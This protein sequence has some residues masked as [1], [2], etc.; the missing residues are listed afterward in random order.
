MAEIV[1]VS[2]D[3][4]RHVFP[5]GT[6]REVINRA[7]KKYASTKFVPMRGAAT[8]V[9][10]SSASD[11]PIGERF[12]QGLMDIAE[13][14]AQLAAHLFPGSMPTMPAPM[15]PTSYVDQKVAEGQQAYADKRSTAGGQGFDFP[16]TVGNMSAMAPVA[17]VAAPEAAM[18][19]MAA[20]GLGA[21]T[22]AGTSALMPVTDTEKSFAGQKLGQM[23]E[24][25]IAGLL[26]GGLTKGLS[27]VVKPKVS[28]EIELLKSKGVTPTLGQNLGPM[29]A[30]MEDR[31]TGI[32]VLGNAIAGAQ[33]RSLDQFNKAVLDD[34]LQPI[35][36]SA[37]GKIG[38]DGADEVH[39]ILDQGYKELLPKLTYKVDDQFID[40]LDKLG[41]M[42]SELPEAQRTRFTEIVEKKLIDRLSKTEM[43]DGQTWKGVESELSRIAMELRKDASFDQRELGSAVRE[44]LVAFRGNLQRTNPEFAPQLGKLND[45]YSR[46][47]QLENATSRLGTDDGV[48]T[49]SQFL[50]AVRQTDSSIRKSKFARGEA[51][52]QDMARAGKQVLGA[53]YPDSGTVGRSV[54][55]A[56]ALG[57]AGW[58]D[59]GLTLGGL[60]AASAPY[61][62]PGQW[63]MSAITAGKRP[64]AA[65]PIAKLLRKA[66]VPA[67]SGA[68]A[69]TA[70]YD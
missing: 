55:A 41:A 22:G 19:W 14:G 15:S 26:S 29:A 28:P 7:M 42:A 47:V 46:L 69:G 8:M 16:R 18:G 63:L 4:K 51:Q 27:S 1:A 44:I 38:Y 57:A 31:L 68:A 3:G 65:D 20:L 58:G 30:K 40:D 59:M 32:P 34:V 45:S 9:P 67:S 35:G 49:P 54:P 64:A 6:S 36:K 10:M 5:E 62:T 12:K 43:M 11:L 39:T 60:T 56:A 2:A 48:F 50:A 21:A 37:P 52:S 53:K 66:V 25:A 61:I 23:G 70:Q 17:A 13:G 24:G 33:K